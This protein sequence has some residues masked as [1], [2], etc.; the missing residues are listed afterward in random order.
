MSRWDKKQDAKQYILTYDPFLSENRHMCMYMYV[1]LCADSMYMQI[2]SVCVRDFLKQTLKP[3][4]SYFWGLG[5]WLCGPRR[6][7]RASHFIH[8]GWNFL[9]ICA[10]FSYKYKKKTG[11]KRW[12]ERE[13][14]TKMGNRQLKYNCWLNIITSWKI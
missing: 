5:L 4:N 13:G 6:Q 7:A 11:L 9:N 8:L 2:H 10:C 3:N 12:K 14:K 1:S